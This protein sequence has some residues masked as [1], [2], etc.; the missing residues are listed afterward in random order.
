MT[1]SV[2]KKKTALIHKGTRAI[3]LPRY[4][5][6]SLATPGHFVDD[7]MDAASMITEDEPVQ[8]YWVGSPN[9]D[10]SEVGGLVSH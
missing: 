5:P 4:H 9:I 7:T 8:V 10:I 1:A 6:F 2:R 3:R